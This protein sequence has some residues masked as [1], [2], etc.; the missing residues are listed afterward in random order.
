MHVAV[1]GALI[2]FVL[3]FLDKVKPTTDDSDSD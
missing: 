2:M 3:A 1:M